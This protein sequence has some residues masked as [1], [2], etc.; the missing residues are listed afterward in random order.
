VSQKRIPIAMFLVCLVIEVVITAYDVNAL[1]LCTEN[2]M[3]F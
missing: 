2:S 3:D 1:Q